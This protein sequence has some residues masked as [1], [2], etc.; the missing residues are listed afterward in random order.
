MLRSL[1]LLAVSASLVPCTSAE[2]G[3]ASVLSRLQREYTAIEAGYRRNDPEPWLARLTPDFQLTLFGGDVKDRAWVQSYV[4]NNV[5]AFNIVRLDMR[6]EG[7][8]VE[9][10]QAVATVRQTSLRTFRDEKGEHRLEVDARQLETW[11]RAGSGW[12]LWRVREYQVLGLKQD[13]VDLRPPAASG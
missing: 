10:S 7:V 12:R 3:S 13:G 4:R 8:R 11:R 5:K 9:G 2:T 1:S 6:I